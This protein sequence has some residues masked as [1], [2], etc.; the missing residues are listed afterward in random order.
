[1]CGRNVRRLLLARKFRF[2]KIQQK[3]QK[4]DKACQDEFFPTLSKK[5]KI[6]QKKNKQKT[7]KKHQQHSAAARC[8]LG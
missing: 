7:K 2:K 3:I 5:K 1:V 4:A 8:G 6:T